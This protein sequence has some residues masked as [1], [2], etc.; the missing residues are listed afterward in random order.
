M[1]GRITAVAAL[2]NAD[3]TGDESTLCVTVHALGERA[4]LHAEVKVRDAITTELAKVTEVSYPEEWDLSIPSDAGAVV[5]VPP[6]TLEYAFVEE[7]FREGGFLASAAGGPPSRVMGEFKKRIVKVERVQHTG[8]WSKFC[9]QRAV[10]A[11]ANGGNPNEQWVK[12]GTRTTPPEKLYTSDNGIDPRYCDAGFF[13]KAAYFAERAY[14]SHDWAHA[15]GGGRRQMFLARII[16]GRVEERVRDGTAG[17]LRHPSPGY[18]SVR[19]NVRTDADPCYAYM[20][21]ELGMSYP[22]YLITYSD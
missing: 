14:Y 15:I 4:L 1:L 17:G 12:H 8:I 16:A 21:Y 11:R 6:G 2:E 9:G 10:V 13:G 5:E 3:I 18:H 20:V 19:G 22:A 7:R